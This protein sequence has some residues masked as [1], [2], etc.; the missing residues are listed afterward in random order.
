MQN[1]GDV[2]MDAGNVGIGTT[3]PQTEL[4]INKSTIGEYLRVG[5]GGLRELRF[6][7]YNTTS[8][9]AGHKIDASS[10]NG[11][12]ALATGGT[13]RMYIGSTGNIG[14]GTASPSQILTVRKDSS[15]TYSSGTTSENTGDI[16]L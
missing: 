4:H 11:E 1:D 9:H 6:S 10:S 14:I 15:T 5:S 7:S 12:I 3:S 2:I 8:D 13:A 16:V